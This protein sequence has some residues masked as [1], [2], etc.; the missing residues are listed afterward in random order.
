MQVKTPP[1]RVATIE[2]EQPR[3]VITLVLVQ[4]EAQASL[5]DVETITRVYRRL[6]PIGIYTCFCI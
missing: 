1:R 5:R 4:V 6:K 3:L 2:G